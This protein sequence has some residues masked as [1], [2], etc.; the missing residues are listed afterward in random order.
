[1]KI[2]IEKSDIIICQCLT[3]INN[4]ES[5]FIDEKSYKEVRHG[6]MPLLDFD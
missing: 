1:M 5:F 3:V 4:I 2:P 6:F